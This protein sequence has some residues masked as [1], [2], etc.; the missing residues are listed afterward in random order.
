MRAGTILLLKASAARRPRRVLAAVA[1]ALAGCSSISDVP[2][3]ATSAVGAGEPP[4]L[5]V[6]VAPVEAYTRIARGANACWLSADGPLSRAYILHADVKPEAEGGSGEIVL[7]ERAIGQPHPWGPSTFRITLTRMGEASTAVSVL[8]QTMPTVVA[9]AMRS[10]VTRFARGTL[11]CGP[12][13]QGLVVALPAHVV[14]GP[15][16][17]APA[18]PTPAAAKATA[19]PARK[20]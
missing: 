8:N 7:H 12:E 6:D 9:A 17:P 3:L 2:K 15:G 10:D 13:W 5:I 19:A 18:V 4:L 11:E 14:R 16:D 20:N 1:L